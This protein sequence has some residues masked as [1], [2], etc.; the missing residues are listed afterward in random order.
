MKFSQTPRRK[1]ADWGCL[2]TW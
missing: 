1:A 2:G